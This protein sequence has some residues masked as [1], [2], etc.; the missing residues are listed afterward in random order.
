MSSCSD[1]NGKLFKWNIEKRMIC[2]D[3]IEITLS[4][5]E[6]SYTNY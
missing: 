6:V 5:P 2:S 1:W 4:H 3:H